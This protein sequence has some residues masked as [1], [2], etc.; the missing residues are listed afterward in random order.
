MLFR[1]LA[2]SVEFTGFCANVLTQLQRAH[3]AV[4][5]SRWE[6][7]SNALL[8]AM[9]CGLACVATR[10][11]GSED[12]LQE[13]TYGL[14]VEPEDAEGLATAL[15]RLLRQP[16]L[17]QHYGQRARQYVEQDHAFHR[18]MDRYIELYKEIIV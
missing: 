4:L 7:M 18:V 8:E 16:D 1:S 3:I 12:L 15:L 2:S 10:V 9:S 5:P 13:D 14:L 6:G 17:A 11:S